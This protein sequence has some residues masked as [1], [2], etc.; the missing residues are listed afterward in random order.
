MVKCSDCNKI[1]SFGFPGNKK[2]YCFTHKKTYMI[3]MTSKI[4]CLNCNRY[5][6]YDFNKMKYCNKH[7]KQWMIN[8][9]KVTLALCPDAIDAICLS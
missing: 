4:M 6:S 9:K 2:K 5:A 8:L 1:G 3:N 7:K